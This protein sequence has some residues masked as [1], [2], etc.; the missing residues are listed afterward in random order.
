MYLSRAEHDHLA[1]ALPGTTLA[2][3]RYSIPPLG[4]DVFDPPLHGLIIAEAEFGTEAELHAFQPPVTWSPMSTATPASPAD[5]WPGLRARNSSAGW[6]ST[7]CR[8]R[9][10]ERAEL[11][12][13]VFTVN[14]GS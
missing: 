12:Y 7:A 14:A 11:D 13:Q 3:T 2:K 1:A 4:I 8:C 5:A 6:P 9:L 10:S